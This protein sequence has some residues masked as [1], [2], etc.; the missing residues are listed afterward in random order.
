M[1]DLKT[2]RENLRDDLDSSQDEIEEDL[3]QTTETIKKKEVENLLL[4][5]TAEQLDQL[6]ESLT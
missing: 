1:E 2:I 5:A 3:N 4:T 6:R